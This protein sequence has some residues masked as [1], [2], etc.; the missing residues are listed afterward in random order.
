MR[1]FASIACTI[2]TVSNKVSSLFGI[3]DPNILEVVNRSEACCFQT[4]EVL[5]V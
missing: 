5:I 2:C 1:P 4:L 3:V